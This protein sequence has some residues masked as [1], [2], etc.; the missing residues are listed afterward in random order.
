MLPDDLHQMVRGYQS[1]RILLTGVELNVFTSIGAGAT[2]AQVAERVGGDVRATEALLGALAAVGL[3]TKSGDEFRN[4]EPATRF[5]TDDSPESERMATMHAVT[6]WNSWSTLTDCVRTGTSVVAERQE[7]PD[8]ATTE[9]FIAAMHRH[10]KERAAHHVQAIG[11]EGVKRLLDIGGG[12]ATY[13]IAFA[14]AYPEIHADVLDR[15]IVIPI[16][17]RHIREAGMTDRI[18]THAGDLTKDSFGTGYDLLLL[19]N[20]C[21]MLGPDE[22]QDLIQRCRAALVPAGRLAIQEFILNDDRISPRDSAIFAINMLVATRSGSSYTEGEYGGWLKE[23]GFA[24]A[25]R[26]SLPGPTD[27]IVATAE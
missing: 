21:H 14:A 26:I 18:T 2:A 1:S 5:F 27:L 19:F 24:D 17:E 23:A 20:I 22:N 3:L 4:T 12:P 13:A 6:Q 10:G 15:P 8:P 9:A 16:A 7:P 25:R 11:G